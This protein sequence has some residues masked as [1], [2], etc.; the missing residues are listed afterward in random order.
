MLDRSC[1]SPC[2]CATSIVFMDC[3]SCIFGLYFLYF[4]TVFLVFMGCI[5]CIFGL[6][7]L[8]FWTVFPVFLDC[9][10]W[11]FGLYFSTPSMLLLTVCWLIPL[12]TLIPTLN[13]KHGCMGF[14]F[15][16]STILRLMY[17]V[18]ISFVNNLNVDVWGLYF[19]CQ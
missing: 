4:W 18:C 16:L 12:L 8:Y 19:L 6:Y 17:G 10:S 11:I 2:V 7:F 5:S 14:V 3:I 15:N 1:H 9:I 13:G